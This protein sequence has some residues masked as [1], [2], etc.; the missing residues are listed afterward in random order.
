MFLGFFARIAIPVLALFLT[1]AIPCAL[2]AQPAMLGPG[3]AKEQLQLDQRESS[4]NGHLESTLRFVPLDL[5]GGTQLVLVS[6]REWNPIADQIGHSLEGLHTRFS[7]MFGDIPAF[8]SSI[9]LMDEDMFFRTTG[10]PKWTNALFLRGE[11]IIPISAAGPPSA[12]SLL[13]TVRHEYTHAVI[14]AMSDGRCP[15]WL[16]EGIAQWAE[17][18]E[19]PA[20][21]PALARW[22]QNQSPV[23]LSLLQGGFTRL[24]SQM[25]P[26]AYAQSLFAANTVINTFGFDR[27]RIYLDRLNQGL[28]SNRAFEKSFNISEKQFEGQLGQQLRRWSRSYQSHHQHL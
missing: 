4:R 25:V 20:L 10:A 26:A 28:D 13:R 14:H 19:N 7:E 2:V 24:D 22:L 9:R 3:D 17:G 23:S 15:G 6:P 5:K 16:D 12:E 21:R 18:Q 8:K 11:I 1:A 27:V